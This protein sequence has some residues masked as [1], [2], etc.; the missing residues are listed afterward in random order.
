MAVAAEVPPPALP[1]ELPPAFV[2]VLGS[3][4]VLD[5]KV[6]RDVVVE[7]SPTELVVDVLTVAVPETV[8]PKVDLDIVCWVDEVVGGP[9]FPPGQLFP[10]V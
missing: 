4:V 7:L 2:V 1:L 3:A 6:L 8:T 10:K 5:V 9:G